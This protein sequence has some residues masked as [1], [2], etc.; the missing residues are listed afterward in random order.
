MM[1]KA[2]VALFWYP[3]KTLNAKRTPCRIFECYTWWYVQ[4]TLGFKRLKDRPV[5]FTT[6]LV[7]TCIFLLPPTLAYFSRTYQPLKMKALQSFE[8]SG[9]GTLPA[10]HNKISL[11]QD[12]HK[13]TTIIHV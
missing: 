11:D 12:L 13:A 9:H 2:K 5:S 3:Y 6:A 1:Y 4:E 10:I 7:E 8:T